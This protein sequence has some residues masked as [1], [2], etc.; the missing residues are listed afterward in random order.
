VDERAEQDLGAGLPSVGPCA[1]AAERESHIDTIVVRGIAI[2][3]G[4]VRT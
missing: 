4:S 3:E 1:S 2:E